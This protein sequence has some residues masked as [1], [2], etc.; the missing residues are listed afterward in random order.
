MGAVALTKQK[1]LC[2]TY[3]Y[4]IPWENLIF[5]EFAVCIKCRVYADS[6]K[7]PSHLS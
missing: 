6:I 3:I 1:F 7:D 4:Y 2:Y 5:T